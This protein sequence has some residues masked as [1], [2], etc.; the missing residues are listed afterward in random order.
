MTAG[1]GP[2]MNLKQ[3]VLSGLFWT[4]SSRVIGQVV[5]WAITIVVIR[6]LNP[7][8]YGLL[9]MA[10]VFVGFVNMF[11]EAGFGAA[12]VQAPQ[13]DDTKLRRIFGAVILIDLA[14]FA[15]QVADAAGRPFL[16]GRA[17]DVGHPRAGAA[18]PAVAAQPDARARCCPANLTS[19]ASR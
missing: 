16:R 3:K 6:L 12:V 17:A 8:D 10:M 15:L 1:G 19:S 4:G 2:V 11:S 13:L 14:L 7:A 18:Y 5:N 9:A